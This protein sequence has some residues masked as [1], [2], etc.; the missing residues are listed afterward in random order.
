MKIYFAIFFSLLLTLAHAQAPNIPRGEWS[1]TDQLFQQKVKYILNFE[2]SSLAMLRGNQ[3]IEGP[4]L[5]I[6]QNQIVADFGFG[7]RKY[8]L[9]EKGKDFFCVSQRELLTVK[10]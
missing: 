1:F 6:D 8:V 9:Q 10:N 4:R 2:S 3:K 5:K 7:E